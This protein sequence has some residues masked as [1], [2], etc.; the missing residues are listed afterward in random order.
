MVDHFAAVGGRVF[1]LP[2]DDLFHDDIE[3]ARAFDGVPIGIS[4]SL[5]EEGR[6]PGGL[7]CGKAPNTF[8]LPFLRR[9]SRPDFQ[10]LDQDA[11]DGVAFDLDVFPQR[12]GVIS[13]R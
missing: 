13:W 4:G 10:H 3:A 5:A 9:I 2:L 8:C 12:L 1:L 6:L 7:P 11:G